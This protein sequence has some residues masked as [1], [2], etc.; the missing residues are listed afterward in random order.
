MEF[1]PPQLAHRGNGFGPT[2]LDDPRYVGE[3]KLDGLRTQVHVEG[4]RTVSVFSRTGLAKRG[5]GLEWLYGTTWAVRTAILD[6]EIWAEG[7]VASDVSHLVS[8]GEPVELALFDVLNLGGK[9][10]LRREYEYRRAV[11]EEIVR[12]QANPRIQ[13][14]RM[15]EDKRGLLAAIVA[16]GGEGIVMKRRDSVYVPG[17]RTRAWVKLHSETRAREYDVVLTGI[18]E[19]STYAREQFKTGE[20]AWT[21]GVW[22]PRLGKLRTV[23]QIGRPG[24]R[25]AMLRDVGRVAVVTAKY[26]FPSGALRHGHFQRCRGIGDKTIEECTVESQRVAGPF[27]DDKRAEDC[28]AP[29]ANSLDGIA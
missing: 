13:A 8:A 25:D 23:G 1:I 24:P 15:A 27:R 6:G 29:A 3:G 7:V 5:A 28:V 2:L 20:A 4:H 16:E 11:V 21:Y 12:V 19:K 22:D 26:Q 18:T 14:T 9:S 17:S 10:I